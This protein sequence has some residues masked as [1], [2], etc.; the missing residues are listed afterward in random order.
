[1]CHK[2]IVVIPLL[3]AASWTYAQTDT[4]VVRP[5]EINDVLVN[6]GMGIQTFQ[7]FNGD[8]I[9]AGLRWSEE[10]PATQLQAAPQK[11][12]FPDSPISYCR[13][14]WSA[15]EP[16]HGQ[17]RWD[18]IDLA[19]AEARDHHQRLAIRI[20]PYDQK[21]PLPDWYRNSGAHRANKPTDK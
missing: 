21:H 2:W 7:R 5:R 17:F 13:W 3:I 14:F 18:I 12:D 11:P 4:V 16:K 8:P 15:I 10:G 19:L 6:P 20:M 9:N 1:M